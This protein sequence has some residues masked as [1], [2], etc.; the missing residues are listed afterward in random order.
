[1]VYDWWFE[2]G[3]GCEVGV[4][5]VLRRGFRVIV[6][7]ERKVSLCGYEELDFVRVCLGWE[8]GFF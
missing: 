3:G 5:E 8:V 7:M 2:D 1:M 6:S 4:R